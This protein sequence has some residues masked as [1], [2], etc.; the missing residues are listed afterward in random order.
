MT[1]PDSTTKQCC[2]CQ[3]VFEISQF[4]RD[5]SRKDGRC[6]RCKA[7]AKLYQQNNLSTFAKNAKRWREKN[8]EAAQEARERW[9][10][11]NPNKVKEKHRRDS[12][13][14][15]KRHPELNSAKVRK[16]L[17]VKAGA[18]G[19]GATLSELALI[20][21][22]LCYLCGQA[23]A[24]V[25]EHMVPLSRGGTNYPS[26]LRPSCLACNSRKRNKTVEEFLRLVINA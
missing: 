8:P 3:L 25:V 1:T 20:H 23:K 9:E 5:K 16:Y 21:G 19:D 18:P 12:R 13:A 22:P 26:N 10:L 17:A 7:C 6:P 14:W 2:V 15:A 4:H 24:T 11:D